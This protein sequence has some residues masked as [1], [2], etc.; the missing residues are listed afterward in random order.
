MWSRTDPPLFTTLLL[1]VSEPP[2]CCRPTVP[3]LSPARRSLLDLQSHDLWSSL[4]QPGYSGLPKLRGEDRKG[5]VT[6]DMGWV[7]ARRHC[8]SCASAL[9]CPH[10]FPTLLGNFSRSFPCPPSPRVSSLLQE[11]AD[12]PD[13]HYFVIFW[14]N[15][16]MASCWLCDPE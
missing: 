12:L 15:R 13:S 16:G 7:G 9:S 4:A 8:P 11:A 6:E 14:W 5:P 2:P 3:W 10:P 1:P